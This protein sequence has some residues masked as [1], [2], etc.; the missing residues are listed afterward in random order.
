L[1]QL[2]FPRKDAMTIPNDNPFAADES[3]RQLTRPLVR[4]LGLIGLCCVAVYGLHLAS[5][6]WLIDRL[7]FGLPDHPPQIQAERLRML[8]EFGA[9][10]VPPLV[11][12]VTAESDSLAS[13]AYQ[14]LSD[15]QGRWQAGS[16]SNPAKMNLALVD[17]VESAFPTCPPSRRGRLVSLLNQTILDT[18][19]SQSSKDRQSYA[20]ATRLLALLAP[21][22]NNPAG[23]ATASGGDP[24]APAV[25]AGTLSTPAIS[26][27][28]QS[29]QSGGLLPALPIPLLSVADNRSSTSDPV[30]NLDVQWIDQQ[31]IAQAAGPAN[32][33]ANNPLVK[34][35]RFEAAPLDPIS[36]NPLEAYD[37]RS[38]IGF[39]ASPQPPLELAARGELIRRGFRDADLVLASRL[40]SADESVRMDMVREISN[41]SD[42]DPRTWLLWLADDASRWV[43]LEAVSIL[44]TMDDPAVKEALRDRLSSE[45]DLGVASRLRKVLDLR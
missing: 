18:V 21:G 23:G 30:G 8:A 43:R 13:A 9:D 7:T 10:G 36:D 22:Q 3:R 16:I 45:R 25:A 20:K 42:I 33:E 15:M 19:Q 12:C 2:D 40:V 34:D 27:N 14:V 4:T 24:S 35:L 29:Q 6:Y 11:Q 37:T 1:G 44:G 28:W 39:L 32:G 17:A 26:P 38:V 41:R 5:R 31:R